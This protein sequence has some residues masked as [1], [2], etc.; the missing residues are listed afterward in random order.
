MVEALTGKKFDWTKPDSTK[1]LSD[2]LETDYE[3]L[4]D[5]KFNSPLYA[6]LKLNPSTKMAEPLKESEIK[7]LTPA[8]RCTY[9]LNKIKK[10]AD[11]KDIGVEDIGSLEVKEATLRNGKLNLVVPAPAKLTTRISNTA[12]TRAIF[13]FVIPAPRRNPG[14]TPPGAAW[15]DMGD[16]FKDVTEFNDPIQGAVANCYFIAALSAIAWA[17]PY[18]IIHRNRATGPGETDRVNAIQFYSKSSGHN[19]PTGLVEVTDKT[20]VDSSNNPIYCH[21]GDNGEIWP[22]LYEKAFA[23]WTTGDTTDLPDITQTAYGDCVAATAQINNKT[24]LYY[25]TGSRTPD[26]LFTIVR[27]NSV[28][29]KTIYP[30][31]AWTPASGPPFEGANIVAN[32]CYTVLGWATRNGNNYIVLRNPWRI[33]EPSGLNTIQG[34]VTFFDQ[35]FWRP[36]NTIANDGIFALE[37]GAFKI[38]FAGLGVAK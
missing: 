3:Q 35:T 12:I 4:F 21:S 28:I 18:S 32:H 13:D 22:A 2:V 10:L 33:V 5:M 25:D 23:K 9:P 7:I 1:I 38:F 19:G 11:L 20:L 24:P 27:S 26:Q 34:V 14:W 37:M 6:G 16:F 17:D 15:R 31:T 30:M 36:I 29:F 8:D